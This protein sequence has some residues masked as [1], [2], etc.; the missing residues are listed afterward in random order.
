MG[1][2]GLLSWRVQASI[3]KHVTT[4]HCMGMGCVSCRLVLRC[5]FLLLVTEVSIQNGN[6]EVTRPPHRH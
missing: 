5:L 1:F 6:Q 2:G 3:A 4:A